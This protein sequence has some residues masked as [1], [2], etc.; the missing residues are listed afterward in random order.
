VNGSNIGDLT[1][2]RWTGTEWTHEAAVASGNSASGSATTTNN[3]TGFGNFTFANANNNTNPLP[4]KYTFFIAE[5]KNNN[6][7]LTWETASEINNRGFEIQYSG[8]DMVWNP[9]A[10]VTGKG[11]QSSLNRYEF[12]RETPG[13]LLR[14]YRLKQIDFDGKSEFSETRVLYP[15]PVEKGRENIFPNPSK[16]TLH[17]SGL[18]PNSEIQIFNAS[19]VFIAGLH[20]EKGNNAPKIENL[21]PGFYWVKIQSEQDCKTFKV[22]VQ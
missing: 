6:D 20:T 18:A 1:I 16:G 11:N 4:V 2:G 19:G 17:F 7:L 22:V 9:V 10:W 5:R 3:L 8:S 21:V 13:Q 14:Y 15:L 12:T